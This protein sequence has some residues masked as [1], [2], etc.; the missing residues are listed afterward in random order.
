[1]G[2]GKDQQRYSRA[3]IHEGRRSVIGGSDFDPSNVTQTRDA[4][5][6]IRLE[7]DVAELF[8]CRQ[9]S[10]RFN[11]DLIGLS[12]SDRRLIE[13]ARGNLKVLRPKCSKYLGGVQV[14]GRDLVRIEPDAHRVFARALEL[15]VA[16]A[17]QSCKD[18]LHV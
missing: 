8:G 13:D 5:L 15:N 2:L 6:R 18:V 14:A 11:V 16:D 12:R 17:G 10:E 4:A 9:P 1:L 3:A 7:H